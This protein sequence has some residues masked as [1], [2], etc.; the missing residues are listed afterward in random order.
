MISN[1]FY[2]GVNMNVT[3]KA[4]AD[5]PKD[6]KQVQDFLFK[7]IK[8][9]F[10]YGYVAEWHQDIVNMDEYYINPKRNNFFVAYYE[11]GEIIATIGI[12][13]YDKDFP[14]FKYLY[15]NETT[16]SI[17]RLFVDRRCRRCGLASKMFS[18]A[19]NFANQ[20]NYDNIYL[21]THKTL[22]GALEFW[23]KMGFIVSLDSN[24]E[25]ETVHMDKRIHE[26][27][28]SSLANDFSYAVKL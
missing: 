21:H 22:D 3:I 5:N 28:I 27:E 8:E 25:L 15:S 18:V 19:E 23:T 17:W 7:M 11:T 20:Q 1:T 12:R 9:E 26:L 10:G 13:A 24:D 2:D 4:L 6:I 14:E 16:S